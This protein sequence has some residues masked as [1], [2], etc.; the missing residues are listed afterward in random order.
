MTYSPYM[1]RK[2][3]FRELILTIIYDTKEEVRRAYNIMT[4]GN[5]PIE[6]KRYEAVA[7]FFNRI[8]RGTICSCVLWTCKASA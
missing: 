2:I 3:C 5:E 1:G 8:H 4:A 7:R 6:Y